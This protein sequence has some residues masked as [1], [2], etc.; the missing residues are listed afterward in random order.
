MT[1]FWA[2]GCAS[3]NKGRKAFRQISE[4]STQLS[5]DI[6]QNFPAS[7][8]FAG[9]WDAEGGRHGESITRHIRNQRDNKELLSICDAGDNVYLLRRI[10]PKAG[11]P[12]D[13]IAD[14]KMWRPALDAPEK[15]T[16]R[17]T[18]TTIKAKPKR[19]RRGR[20]DSEMEDDNTD[21]RYTITR[22][23]ILRIEPCPCRGECSCPRDGRL[24]YKRDEDYDCS[25]I[26]GTRSTYCFLFTKKALR[27][28]TRQY[29]CYC[30]W[31]ARQRYDKCNNVDVVRHSN[32]VRPTDSHY[33]RWRDEGWRR[34]TQVIKSR[35]DS[36]V[37]RVADQSLQA[38]RD[39]VRALD[40]GATLAVMTKGA[41]DVTKFWLASKHS[42]PYKAKASD[43]DTG[44]T[45]GELI[46]NIIWYESMT[47]YKYIKLDDVCQVSVSSVAVTVSNITHYMATY[48]NQ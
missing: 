23:H 6:L 16:P 35:P 41:D 39:Y 44:I 19:Q 26:P 10:L 1:H 20:T 31:C 47:Q 32:V 43:N 37:T 21:P 13:P 18:T 4:L 45:R 9:N 27:C 40:V 46:L 7:H 15:P 42:D 28:D 5:I 2:D 38:A 25:H 29:S 24:V 8:H 14:Q 12:D 17:P 36:S 48:H 30:R 22:R 34:V 11:E 3:Q 33:R